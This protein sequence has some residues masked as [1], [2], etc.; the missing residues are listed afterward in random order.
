MNKSKRPTTP[1]WPQPHLVNHSRRIYF[2]LHINQSLNK[3]VEIYYLC[4][5]YLTLFRQYVLWWLEMLHLML[6]EVQI[7][8]LV[9]FEKM[10]PV[11]YYYRTED[12]EKS[13]INVDHIQQHMLIFELPI[14]VRTV[15]KTFINVA[16][17]W[18]ILIAINENRLS[19]CSFYLIKVHNLNLIKLIGVMPSSSSVFC[20]FF[21]CNKPW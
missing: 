17:N 11:Y 9:M 21:T 10:R 18:L 15:L 7:H 4:E 2:F 6:F 1:A 5:S 12:D 16:K 19:L 3:L 8:Y 20:S 13:L 14:T